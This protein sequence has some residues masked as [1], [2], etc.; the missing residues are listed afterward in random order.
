M[1]PP[2]IAVDGPAGSGKSSVCRGVAERLGLRYL[3]TGAMYRAMTWAMLTAGVDVDDPAAVAAHTG[4]VRIISGTDPRNPTI[5]VGASDVSGPIRSD[6]VTGAVSAVS[7]VPLVRD[8][9][10]DVQRAEVAAARDAGEGIVVEGRDITTV[11]LPD[12]DLKVFITADPAI[13]AARRAAQDA[14][15]GKDG[16][17]VRTTETALLERDAKDSTRTTSPLAQ[18]PDAVVVDTTDLTLEQVID[19]VCDLT[20]SRTP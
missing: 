8:R 2:V 14:D 3:D 11:V 9:L 20:R 12:A 1:L 7:A 6:E 16:V 4:A 19:R 10:V 13:R 17:D 15:L 5:H 18:A